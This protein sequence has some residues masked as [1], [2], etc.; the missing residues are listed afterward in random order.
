[1]LIMLMFLIFD[2]DNNRSC[3]G[4]QADLYSFVYTQFEKGHSFAKRPAET[5][6]GLLV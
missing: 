5:V 4:D 3:C 2:N 1:M 6:C